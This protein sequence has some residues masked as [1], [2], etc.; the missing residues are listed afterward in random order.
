[1]IKGILFDKDGTLV[2][3]NS[4]WL[5][6]TYELIT[7]IAR[8]HAD[9]YSTEKNKE[10]ASLLGLLDNQID[11]HSVL[12]SM[13]SQDIAKIIADNLHANVEQIHEEIND[14]YYAYIL[15]NKDKI[16]GIGNLLVLLKQLKN[17]GLII[18]IVTADNL[19]ITKLTLSVLE[20][21]PYVD[22]IATADLYEKKPN[23]E[24]MLAFC[25]K[26]SLQEDEV[27]HV[28]DT[29]IDMKF[30]KHGKFGVGVLS[31]VGT[32]QTLEKYTPYIIE[33]VHS[34]INLEGKFIYK[35]I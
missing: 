30:S 25:E 18:G 11:E 12:A 16:R 28:G 29:L 6:S 10:I 7:Y 31:G 17:E 35:N 15:K 1:M 33:S 23:K 9:V 34:L 2:D 22:F 26:F 24:A 27:I 20:I 3:F 21:E 5:E 13:T 14:F 32:E 19:D 4:L 8:K